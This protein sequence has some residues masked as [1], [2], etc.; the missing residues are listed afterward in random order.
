MDE[1]APPAELEAAALSTVDASDVRLFASDTHWP[2][3][4]HLRREDPVHYCTDSPYG[5]YWSITRYE[6]IAAIECDYKTF[7]SAGNV[8]IGD[9]PESYEAKAFIIADPP[10]HTRVRKAVTPMFSRTHMELSRDRIRRTTAACLD[11]LKKEEAINW[12]EAVA[13]PLSVEMIALLFAMPLEER[14]LLPY[15]ADVLNGNVRPGEM[16]WDLAEREV[17]KRECLEKLRQLWNERA[18]GLPP[19]DILAALAQNPT[20]SDLYDDDRHLLG[21]LALIVGAND[22]TRGAICGAVMAFNRFPDQWEA[23]RA[24]P[25]TIP[26]AVS[27][28]VRWHTP[29]THMRR[30]ATKD[31]TFRGRLIRKGERVVLWYCSANRDEAIFE[32]ADRFWIGRP[33][34]RSHLSYGFGIHRCIGRHVAELQL[35]ILLEEL[36]S[37][38]TRIELAETPERSASN[39]LAGFDRL[40]VRAH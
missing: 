13:A 31:V 27:E 34:A 24:D 38:F 16:A 14:G 10:E 23:L 9:V 1:V 33:N 12:T 29:V 7:S 17:V 8:I 6:D 5:P 32:D 21:T 25:A 26:A 11:A 4:A 15:W 36:V 40:M 18:V 22:T 30:T 2:V 39:F 3:F 19:S 37:R 20:V 28:I 35:H